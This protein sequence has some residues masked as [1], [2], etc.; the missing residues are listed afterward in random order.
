MRFD[1]LISECY[2]LLG[3][4]IGCALFGLLIGHVKV[5]VLLGLVSY[6][7]YHLFTLNQLLNWLDRP[8]LEEIPDKAGLWDRV[9]YKL[10]Q[11]KR[12]EI[13]EKK[14]LKSVIFQVESTTA[15]LN[16]AI[17]LLNCEEELAW[18]NAATVR[19]LDLKSNDLGSN[20]RN[21][22]RNPRFINYLE[23]GDFIIPLPL[24]S[25]SNP[26]IQLEFQVTRFGQ[27]ETL[28][29]V[30]DV[31]HIF[32]LEEIRK[33]FVANVS[34]ELRTPL[35]VIR[36]YLETLEDS[37]KPDKLRHWSKA[38][39][40]MHQQA[41]R[42]STLIDDLT[43]LSRLETDTIQ[44]R[45]KAIPLKLLLEIVSSEG[46]ALGA[47]KRQQIVLGCR[48]EVWINGDDRELHSAFSN[49]M[50]NAIKYSD[51]GTT[52]TITARALSNG[53]LVISV[54]DQ[55]IG[56]EQ[57]HISRL[58]ERFYRVDQSRSIASGGTGLGLAIVK[59]I[60]LRH[61]AR[62]KIESQPGEGSIFSCLF[63]AARVIRD[64]TVVA[65]TDNIT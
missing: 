38:F 4:L 12:L 11:A 24:P 57:R 5:A 34:H 51:P 65:A 10:S 19:L 48:D 60:L 40:Q 56:I 25:L 16:D 26:D 27:G 45:Q 17:I 2:R 58:T 64:H 8:E 37:L 23:A 13:R 47:D 36:G 32:K 14:R 54:V 20:I 1:E 33:D 52:V 63:P 28:L 30:R 49:L 62:L 43:I 31:T 6:L 29:V 9:F 39:T 15:A 55:G 53:D 21:F 18:W 22:I 50:S 3:I 41:V 35:T 46:R 7:F 44:Y 61:D 42:M 59:H